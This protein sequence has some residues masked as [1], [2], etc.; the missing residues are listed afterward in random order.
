M[1]A[2][3]LS[4]FFLSDFESSISNLFDKVE[5]NWLIIVNEDASGFKNN[6]LVANLL[7]TFV[8][9][10]SIC[11]SFYLYRWRK[12]LLANPH[13]YLPEEIGNSVGQ[14]AKEVGCMQA[15]VGKLEKTVIKANLELSNGFENI[16]ATLMTLLKSLDDKDQEIARLKQGYDIEIYRKFIARFIRVDLTLNDLIEDADL[17]SESLKQLKRLLSDALDECGVESFFPI[18]GQDYRSAEGVAEN[19]KKQKTDN[20]EDDFKISEIIQC[21][22]RLQRNG[23]FEVIIPAKV[24]IYYTEN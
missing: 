7:L 17:E 2:I 21:G 16:T 10:V 9:F 5:K 1:S 23:S 20:Q 4:L 18:I 24:K 6:L 14:F 3:I 8:L 13:M 15:N 11:I 12:I 22:Y 19:P